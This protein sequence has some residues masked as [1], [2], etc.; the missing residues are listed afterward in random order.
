MN[1]A[2]LISLLSISL[3]SIGFGTH[4]DRYPE[5]Y[6]DEAFLNYPSIQYSRLGTYSYRHSGDTPYGD[7][8]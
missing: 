4:L 6:R 3:I 2:R 1:Q 7:E 8:V 5:F